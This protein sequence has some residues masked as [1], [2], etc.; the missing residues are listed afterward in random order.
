MLVNTEMEVVVEEKT[1]EEEENKRQETAEK[2]VVSRATRG[3]RDVSIY[4][5][6]GG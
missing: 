5:R 1:E 2:G 3:G 6:D 4:K